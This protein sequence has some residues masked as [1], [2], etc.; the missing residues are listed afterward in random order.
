MKKNQT[1]MMLFIFNQRKTQLTT[2]L[3]KDPRQ[4]TIHSDLEQI[5]KVMQMIHNIPKL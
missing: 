4:Q 5:Q 1:M 2:T 3:K